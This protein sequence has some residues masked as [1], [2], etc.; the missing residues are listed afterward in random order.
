MSDT[1]QTQLRALADKPNLGPHENTLL[2]RAADCIDTLETAEFGGDDEIAALTK[3][4]DIL[5]GQNALLELAVRDSKEA[6]SAWLTLPW[7]GVVRK[8]EVSAALKHTD[9][10]GVIHVRV[11]RGQ[12]AH[13]SYG[14]ENS[15]CDEWLADIERQLGIER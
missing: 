12:V 15:V 13:E 6:S 1:I 10:M 5:K 9:G 11:W 2:H 3:E 7:G 8:S 4:R 14:N